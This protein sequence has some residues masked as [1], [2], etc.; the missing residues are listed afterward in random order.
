MSRN[1][2]TVFPGQKDVI[3][4]CPPVPQQHRVRSGNKKDIFEEGFV[5]LD[6]RTHDTSFTDCH[7]QDIEKLG[8]D[9]DEAVQAVWP[10]RYDARYSQAHVLLLSWLDDDLGVER[11]IKGLRHVFRDIYKFTV[12]EYRI[13]SGKP[14][15]SLKRTMCQFLSEFDEKETL[16]IVYYGGHARRGLQSNEGS[17]WFPYVCPFLEHLLKA[18]HLRDLVTEITSPPLYHPVVFNPC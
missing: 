2:P 10:K 9:L 18:A 16:L 11:E 14:D 7:I 4:T 12:H 13:P 5:R 1:E 8:A 17:L 3:E 6:T 15:M